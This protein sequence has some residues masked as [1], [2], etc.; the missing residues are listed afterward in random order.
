[1]L[2]QGFLAYLFDL[3]F[4]SIIVEQSRTSSSESRVVEGFLALDTFFLTCL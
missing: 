1:M 2:F 3:L 4:Q